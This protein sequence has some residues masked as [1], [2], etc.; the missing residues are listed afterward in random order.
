MS[1]RLISMVIVFVILCACAI[2]VGATSYA[3]LRF[4]NITITSR[5]STQVNY[6]YTIK[7]F[8]NASVSSLYNV[9]IQNFY[10][11][12][13]IFN[14]SGDVAAGGSIL[15]ANVSLAAGASYTGTFAAYGAVPSGK[16]YITAKI[17]WGNIVTESNENNN[18]IAISTAGTPD[19]SFTNITITSRTSTQVNY[20]YTIRNNGT[21][22]IPS[23][24]NVSIQN[25]YSADT[26]FNNSGD[27]AAGGSI[28]GTFAS[29]APG[30]SYTGTFAAYGAIPS[31]KPYITAKIDWGNAIYESNE[32]NNT[33][34]IY[35]Q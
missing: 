29:L 15:A 10:S 9:S 8:G 22:A 31:G 16:P 13:T 6:S 32:N 17:D 21:A 28:L 33:V 20:T 1:R 24:Y 18:T 4:T 26:I 19:L 27:V 30:Q 35:A 7:N 12:N 2:P 14:D 3:D 34:A 5:T 25:F 11:A 23:L